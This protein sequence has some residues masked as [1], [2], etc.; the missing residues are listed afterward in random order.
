[1][2]EVQR[3]D[4][5]RTAAN[6]GTGWTQ[7]SGTFSTDG[8]L[9]ATSGSGTHH[10]YIVTALP[11]LTG[12]SN[13]RGYSYRMR[14]VRP[15]QNT[16]SFEFGLTFG[17]AGTLSASG[18]RLELVY[19]STTNALDLRV[20]TLAGT[21]SYWT[22]GGPWTAGESK[23]MRADFLVNDAVVVTFA[24]L[25]LATVTVPSS[26]FFGRFA[27]IFASRILPADNPQWDYVS[28]WDIVSNPNAETPPTSTAV[29]LGTSV[30]LASNEGG[31]ST[32]LTAKPDQHV[33][34]EYRR[35]VLR[36]PTLAGYEV[37]RPR[38]SQ[39][40]RF[41]GLKWTNIAKSDLTSLI[42]HFNSVN[43]SESNFTLDLGDIGSVVG[44]IASSTFEY[45]RLGTDYYS[46]AAVM[47][48]TF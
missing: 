27:G 19:R 31:S 40:R 13:G 35:A 2:P 47:M 21:T 11:I 7:T 12:L 46:A 17:D 14:G 15:N 4:F 10:A 38:T 3:D 23:E 25:T 24:G 37:T 39:T 16:G 45:E 20:R 41:F 42:N 48:E 6:L 36:F 43:G 44:I 8:T 30:A 32:T 1:M 9:A 34:I 5:T 28:V 33:E 26:P 18:I 22:G 29:T